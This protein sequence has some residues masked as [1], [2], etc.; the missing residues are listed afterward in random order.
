MR[1]T[2]DRI[3]APVTLAL[4]AWLTLP[5]PATAAAVYKCSV[6]G[7]VAYQNV[8]CAQG[9]AAERPTVA[10]LNAERQQRL[11]QA[12]SQPAAPAKAAFRCDGRTHCQQM[13]SCAEATYFLAHCPGVKM[14]GD[15]DGVPCEAQWCGH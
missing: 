9:G 2:F 11:Q 14:D 10:Q 12:R 3:W 7:T 15:G 6:N 8:P 5:P 4:W 1:T 13:A